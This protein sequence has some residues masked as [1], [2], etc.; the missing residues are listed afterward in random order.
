[1]A[2]VASGMVRRRGCP[3]G[4][5]A[6]H[7]RRASRRR[8]APRGMGAGVRHSRDTAP[9]QPRIGTARVRTPAAGRQLTWSDDPSL[10]AACGPWSRSRQRSVTEP[11]GARVAFKEYCRRRL[12]SGRI[13]VR[14]RSRRSDCP[15]A[16]SASRSRRTGFEPAYLARSLS[17]TFEPPPIILR[18]AERRRRRLVYIPGDTLPV[19]L[20]GFNTEASGDA[21]APFRWTAPRSPIAPS[22]DSSSRRL[23]Q[24]RRYWRDRRLR[25]AAPL[26]DSTG[27]VGP[28][29][30]GAGRFSNRPRRGTGR[31]RELVR[32]RRVLCDFAARRLPTVYHWARA[33]LA[34]HEITAPLGPSIVPLSNFSGQG[35][36]AGRASSRAWGRTAPYD[37]AGNVREWVWN[38]SS[39][40]RRFVL[41]GAWNEPDYMFSVPNSL[42]PEDRSLANG[43]RCMRLEEEASDSARRCCRRSMCRRRII[44][45]RGR[46]RT[47]CSRCLRSSSPTYPRA[48]RCGGRGARHDAERLDQ[49]ARDD[50]GRL[51]RRADAHLRV[52]A[53]GRH[54]AVSGR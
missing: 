20:S 1:M 30:M 15:A 16:H 6:G 33:A 3:G 42:P 53:A 52:S 17:G 12:A 2:A 5:R 4:P 45:A 8:I 44:A 54:A 21:A 10:D 38:T 50:P 37:M 14:R 51:R 48:A 28:G 47:K 34:P 23:P 7:C 19:N 26:V 11:P 27:R 39:S 18:S 41:G 24:T 35:L 32:G 29:G 31:R 40:G 46:C 25:D 36:G 49:G 43:F 9:R 13:S 22:R